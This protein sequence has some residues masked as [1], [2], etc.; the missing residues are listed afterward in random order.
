[1]KIGIFY[2]STTGVTEAVAERIA[3]KLGVASADVHNVGSATAADAVG[4]DALLLGT[5]TWGAG[6]VQDDWYDGLKVIKNAD[7]GGKTVALFG[8]GDSESYPDTFAGGM[9]ELYQAVVGAGAHVVGAV[10]VDGYTFDSSDAVVDGHFVGLALD[11]VNESDKTDARID[12][13]AAAI[14][15]SL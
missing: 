7:L 12:A 4:Y 2:G 6:E 10:P 1:M 3:K 15:P 11:E 13:W 8:C 5:S 14:T 9:G